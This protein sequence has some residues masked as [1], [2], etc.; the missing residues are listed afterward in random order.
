[1]TSALA[2]NRSEI[3]D[4]RA[5]LDFVGPSFVG[6]GSVSDGRVHFPQ[7][8][9]GGFGGGDLLS[10][11]SGEAHGIAGV[12]GAEGFDG[13][14]STGREQVQERRLGQLDVLAGLQAGGVERG[15]AVLDATGSSWLAS[16]RSRRESFFSECGIPVPALIR[17]ARPG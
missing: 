8:D 13:E 9:L 11:G 3:K 6:I 10:I 1:M 4:A 12:H 7:E 16:P 2:S 5:S 17:W 14:R 15:V